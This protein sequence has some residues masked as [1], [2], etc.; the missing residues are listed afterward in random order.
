VTGGVL[1]DFIVR[2]KR[3]LQ[4]M[5]ISILFLAGK[6]I[7]QNSASTHSPAQFMRLVKL[8]RLP[9]GLHKAAL[10][11]GGTYVKLGSDS[12][13]NMA[14]SLD[15]LVSDSSTIVIGQVIGERA[16]LVN[17]GRAIRTEYTFRLASVLKGAGT[18]SET[19]IVVLPG[20]T[21]RFDDGTSATID[22]FSVP[23]LLVRHTYMI[24]G[25]PLDASP[26][27]IAPSY[28]DQG[29]FELGSDGKTVTPH[30]IRPG[31]TMRRLSNSSQ[32]QLIS[33]VQSSITKD[34]SKE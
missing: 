23:R 26:R 33:D 29:V 2:I 25:S 11:N 4:I 3:M 28:S 19:R 14:G 21:Y 16:V 9:D 1:G 13:W 31:D 24:F 30:T 18:N 22:E 7:P 10:A 34:A 32:A 20:G 27:T 17:D 6:G 5:P 15:D 8:A 12:P